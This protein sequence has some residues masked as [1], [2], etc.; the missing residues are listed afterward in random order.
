MLHAQA[1]VLG[2]VLL[3]TGQTRH[4]DQKSFAKTQRSPV[5]HKWLV[6]ALARLSQRLL[7]MAYLQL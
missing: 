6:G 1:L 4:Y 2:N 5:F 3:R 7:N